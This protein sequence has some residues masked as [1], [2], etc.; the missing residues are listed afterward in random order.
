MRFCTLKLVPPSGS[1]EAAKLLKV[2]TSCMQCLQA[3]VE[4]F[5][6]QLDLTPDEYMSMWEG[7]LHRHSLE[8]G[9]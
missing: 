5:G 8:V 3:M 4:N 2:L 7:L 9:T 1:G 6:L